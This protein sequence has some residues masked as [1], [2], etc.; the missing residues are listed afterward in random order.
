ML[1]EFDEQQTA[2]L[3]DILGMAREAVQRCAP[4]VARLA[5]D[6]LID[7]DI[8]TSVAFMSEGLRDLATL[9]EEAAER[10]VLATVASR[11]DQHRRRSE[12]GESSS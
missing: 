9:S 6:G 4:A 8:A 12:R 7:A 5:Q 2:Y 11:I 1:R 3:I 10:G